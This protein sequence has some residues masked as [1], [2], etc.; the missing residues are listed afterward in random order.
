LV[1]IGGRNREVQNSAGV[2]P[3]A[4]VVGGDYAEAAA[5][6]RE[7]GVK[8][9]AA[10]SHILLVRVQTFELVAKTNLFRDDQ[11]QRRVFDDQIAHE[12]RQLRVRGGCI[13][14]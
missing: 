2:V 6:G 1:V 13:A 3:D 14:E 8:S 5:A 9:L 11:A 12:R 4:A 10:I 7:I